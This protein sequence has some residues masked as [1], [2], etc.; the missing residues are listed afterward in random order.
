[1][2]INSPANGATISGTVYAQGTASD[3]VSL[4]SIQVSLDGGSYANASGTSHWTFGIDTNS[5]SNGPHTIS[6]KVRDAAGMTATS[7]PVGISVKTVRS[8]QTARFML[9]PP[10]MMAIQEQ[11]QQRRKP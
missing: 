11:T 9:R 5:L 8:R 2:V 3:S 10:E 1:V 6:A 4:T 7:S